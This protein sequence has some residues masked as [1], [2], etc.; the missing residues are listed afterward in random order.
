MEHILLWGSLWGLEEATLGHVLHLFPFKI[1]WFF[2]FPL[3]YFFMRQ[4]YHK[5]N[6][7]G[8]VLYTALLAAAFKLI[9]LL[10]PARLDMILN[11]A[12]AILLEG[13]AVFAL[14]RIWEKRPTLAAFPAFSFAG[15]IGVSLLQGV[16]YLAYVFIISSLTPVIPPIKD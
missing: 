6:R 16:L 10:L 1:G 7:A 13:C 14:C 4:V 8:S 3:S 9:D 11:P 12:A 15:T 5:T 2:W